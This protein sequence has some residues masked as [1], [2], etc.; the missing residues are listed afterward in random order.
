MIPSDHFVRFYNEVFKFLDERGDLEE[1]YQEISRH[2]ELHCLELFR[3]KGLQGVY[4]YYQKIRLEENC[5]MDI[6]LKGHELILNMKCCPSLSKAIDNDAGLCIKYCLHCPGWS[7]PLYRRAGFY[8]CNDLK[9]LQTP[10][11][12]EYVSDDLAT[13]R[14]RRAELLRRCPAGNIRWNFD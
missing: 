13:A 6:Q 4:E 7:L 9:G 3:E 10:A 8:A 14:A 5:D 12:T 11:C 1:Y 2:Q